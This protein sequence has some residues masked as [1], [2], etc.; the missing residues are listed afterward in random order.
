MRGVKGCEK[1]LLEGKEE[2][3]FG[4]RVDQIKTE[5]TFECEYVREDELYY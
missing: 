5:S 2:N 3:G 4:G 1:C